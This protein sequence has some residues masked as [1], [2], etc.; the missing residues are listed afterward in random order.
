[1][2]R[3][4]EDSRKIRDSGDSPQILRK[5]RGERNRGEAHPKNSGETREEDAHN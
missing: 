4:P 2:K 1:M 3:H 5:T